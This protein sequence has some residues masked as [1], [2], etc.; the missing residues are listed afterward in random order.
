MAFFNGWTEGNFVPKVV[1][2]CGFCNLPFPSVSKHSWDVN[3]CFILYGGYL[4]EKRV[5]LQRAKNL[6]WGFGFYGFFSPQSRF[7]HETQP[8]DLTFATFVRAHPLLGEIALGNR[9]AQ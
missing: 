4:S 6:W 2:E 8:E 7:E 5:S 9:P 3:Y 1:S